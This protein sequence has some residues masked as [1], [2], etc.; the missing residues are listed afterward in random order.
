[1]Y[2]HIDRSRP[3]GF[4]KYTV[5]PDAL[6]AQ[7]RWLNRRG[8]QTIDLDQLVAARNGGPPLPARPI[9]LTFDD[10]FAGAIELASPILLE[11]GAAAT[12]FVVTDRIGGASDWLARERGLSLPLADAGRLRRLADDGFAVGSHTATHPH[13][14]GLPADRL[15]DELSGARARLEDLLGRPVGHLAYPHGEHDEI[16]RHRAREAG[17]V[18]G[19]TTEAGFVGSTSDPLA[20]P[21][22]IVDGRDRIVDLAAR[23]RTAERVRQ[24]IRS[25]PLGAA[26]RLLRG[27]AGAI[28]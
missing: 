23:L 17:Y 21:R 8:Y 28:R 12:F 26:G 19:V 7:L 5:H 1:M 3:A 14:P 15:A 25:G 18:T 16:V 13:L 11:Q 24:L 10:G 20:M 2:H 27:P 6:R 22:I 4:A 9:V